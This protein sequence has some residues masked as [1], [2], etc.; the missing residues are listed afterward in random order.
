MKNAFDILG[1]PANADDAQIR[2]RYLELVREFPPDR[3]PERFA[4]IREAFDAL[5]D[6]LAQIDRQIFTLFTQDSLQ[7]LTLDI[8]GRLST[9]R[10]PSDVLISLGESP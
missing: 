4:E 1:L 8:R 5:K 2:Q 3:A 7:H 6:P 10:I 9:A